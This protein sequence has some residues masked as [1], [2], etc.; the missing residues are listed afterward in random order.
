MSWEHAQGTSSLNQV[1]LENEL[2]A[3]TSCSQERVVL[4]NQLFSGMSCLREKVVLSQNFHS[5]SRFWRDLDEGK[6]GKLKFYVQRNTY[7]V[8][9]RLW[10]P[11]ENLIEIMLY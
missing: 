6:F 2:S 5:H 1:V 11:Q 3:G 10:I 9:E 7:K 4:K 8:F